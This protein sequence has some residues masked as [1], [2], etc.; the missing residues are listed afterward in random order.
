MMCDLIGRE[1][2]IIARHPLWDAGLDYRHGTG[3]GVGM[4]L[5]VH[6]GRNF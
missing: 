5:S 3:H 6:E 2:E 4:Y 1:I